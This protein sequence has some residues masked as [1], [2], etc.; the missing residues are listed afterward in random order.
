[1]TWARSSWFYLVLFMTGCGGPEPP[2][3]VQAAGEVERLHFAPPEILADAPSL[4]VPADAG[5][6]LLQERLA[7]PR[8]LPIPGPEFSSIPHRHSPRLERRALDEAES[9]PAATVG[10]PA[11]PEARPGLRPEAGRTPAVPPIPTEVPP[12][13]DGA[14]LA[15]PPRRELPAG[16]KAYAEAPDPF[17]PSP[18]PLL[19][20]QPVEDK[21]QTDD[22]TGKA[23]ERAVLT[24]GAILR[25]VAAPL[26]RVSVPDPFENRRAVEL[27][28]LPPE[29]V[30]VESK[31]DRPRRPELPQPEKPAAKPGP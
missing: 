9:L 27:L 16:A 1:M 10:P 30:H 18:L 5:D 28:D 7:P 21:K 20:W 4:P 17:K 11:R 3:A 22:P 6:K 19:V 25:T 13:P 2:A 26:F 14:T 24:A 31:T 29:P 15:L 8:V 23:A 12:F